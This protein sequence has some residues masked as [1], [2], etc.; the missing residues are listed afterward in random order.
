MTWENLKTKIF[1]QKLI[2][3]K[4]K[5]RV[6]I[7]KK[8]YYYFLN[9]EYSF[10]RNINFFKIQN[11][12]SKK[13][14]ILIKSWIFIQTKYSFFSKEA[15][16]PRAISTSFSTF[17]FTSV[18][19]MSTNSTNSLLL[20]PRSV[21]PGTWRIRGACA[22]TCRSTLGLVSVVLTTP[23]CE[24]MDTWVVDT[25]TWLGNLRISRISKPKDDEKNLNW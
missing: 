21:R 10:K 16:S 20:K 4:K 22:A 9:P 23:C 2:H 15:V 17:I 19:K 5:S 18:G 13:V 24:Y 3:F 8:Y 6:F 1:V 25:W 11:I 14:F 12:H 7:Q